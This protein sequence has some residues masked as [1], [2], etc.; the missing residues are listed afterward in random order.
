MD[1][2]A[3]IDLATLVLEM[4][5][6]AEVL[7]TSNISVAFLVADSAT[8]HRRDGQLA[9]A[10][11]QLTGL[12]HASTLDPMRMRSGMIVGAWAVMLTAHSVVACSGADTSLE[13]LPNSSPD[14]AGDEQP[15]FFD[16]NSETAP[17]DDVQP[18]TPTSEQPAPEAA[19]D[20]CSLGT[21]AFPGSYDVHFTPQQIIGTDQGGLSC[22]GCAPCQGGHDARLEI[23]EKQGVDEAVITLQG[24]TPQPV[25]VVAADATI[26]LLGEVRANPVPCG[27]GWETWKQITIAR[28][29][30]GTVASTAEVSGDG[31]VN[32][33]TA[34]GGLTGT[35]GS[36]TGQMT[37]SVATRAPVASTS[38]LIPRVPL[39]LPWTR[40]D[41]IFDAP[42]VESTVQPNLT[43]NA[44]AAAVDAVWSFPPSDAASPTWAGITGASG[45]V[46]DWDQ[47]A[48]TTVA[49]GVGAGF[50]DLTGNLGTEAMASL[51]IP[52]IGSIVTVHEF[53][54]GSI[55]GGAWGN[56]A[57]A[58][59]EIAAF[60]EDPMCLLIDNAAVPCG[61]WAQ[62]GN[63]GYFGRIDATGRHTLSVRYRV[64]AGGPDQSMIGRIDAAVPGHGIVASFPLA[65]DYAQFASIPV[66]TNECGPLSYATDWLEATITLPQDVQADQVGFD[67]E[68]FNEMWEQIHGSLACGLD[69]A[70]WVQPVALLV[71]RVEMN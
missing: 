30:G 40:F 28:C 1:V 64:L 20:W 51:P 42:T 69:A 25:Q 17:P 34:Y 44:N 63:S 31:I 24:G 70:G 59:G 26:E 22:P 29:N 45:V 6:G 10:L 49:W 16:A 67:I 7:S 4:P 15:A 62:V 32:C 66:V 18:D 35:L 11:A 5:S 37:L 46:S 56:A 12:P 13:V 39:V 57:L 55:E 14:V 38:A 3:V 8:T 61:D 21:M 68:L 9:L 54:A 36:M 52:D 23:R 41:V 27:N 58:T 53:A 43:F 2:A 60:C 48:G 71:Q 50:G 19:V 65:P 33:V 47:I